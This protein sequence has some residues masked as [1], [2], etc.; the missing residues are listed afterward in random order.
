MLYKMMLGITAAA[1]AAGI[2]MTAVQAQENPA[3]PTVKTTQLCSY[4]D[5]NGDGICD[6]RGNGQCGGSFVDEM[7]TASAI[8]QE[9]ARLHSGQETAADREEEQR[10]HRT[11]KKYAQ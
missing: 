6:N 1:L 2:G 7:E 10:R 3:D 11:T 4:V 9:A 8:M 5:E